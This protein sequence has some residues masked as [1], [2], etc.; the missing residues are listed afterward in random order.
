MIFFQLGSLRL[1]ALVDTA[2]GVVNGVQGVIDAVFQGVHAPLDGKCRTAA[3]QG[4]QSCAKSC[5][6]GTNMG[7]K[8]GYGV[9]YIANCRLGIATRCFGIAFDVEAA[10]GQL[11]PRSVP[12][13]GAVRRADRQAQVAAAVHRSADTAALFFLQL[14]YID[15]QPVEAVVQ[16]ARVKTA[17][18]GEFGRL[19]VL[20][21]GDDGEQ[22]ASGQRGAQADTAAGTVRLR[23]DISGDGVF[24]RR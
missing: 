12:F 3:L 17:A 1:L 9:A 4:G 8:A 18:V 5:D 24:A 6:F 21:A 15:G 20:H 10:V 14:L 13:Q 23:S 22:V 19:D 16:H 11:L 2:L 7:I